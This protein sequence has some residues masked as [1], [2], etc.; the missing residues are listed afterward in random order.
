MESDRKRMNARLIRQLNMARIF[1]ALRV[2]PNSTQRELA[3]HAGL[4]QATVSTVVGALE[5]D[6]L[7]ERTI[8]TG[9]RRVGR[10]EANLHIPEGAGCL[11][12]ACLEPTTIRVIATD[13]TGRPRGHLQIAG[14]L[15][16]A[17]AL[18][19]LEEGVHDILS[20]CG[21]PSE[22]VKGLGVGVPALMDADGRLA[23]APNLGWRD[24][25]LLPSLQER[26]TMPVYA[27]N[28]TKAAGLAEKLFGSCQDV[29]DFVLIAGHSGLGA[30]LHLDGRLYRARSGFAGELGHVKVRPGG[31]R[32]GCGATGCLEAYLSESAILARLAD[33]GARFAALGEV[34]A[35]ARE[36]D[37]RVLE[38]LDETGAILGEACADLVNLLN[39][40]RI[41]VG[42][43]LTAVASYLLDGA[44]RIL[45]QRAL[46]PPLEQVH[47]GV[48][49]LGVEGV[50][51][52]G[53]ALAMEGFLG[54]PAWLAASQ[55]GAALP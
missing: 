15:D 38:L 52:G 1:H 45:R 44:S 53:V 10:P 3:R 43:N 12:G 11:I 33:R 37:A 22:A 42:G 17:V 41:V 5:R 25:A 6:G 7:I 32:C 24:V 23:Y 19:R 26:F 29:H 28:D 14:S 4:D 51:M 49:P 55:I 34:A 20:G 2:R 27:D 8:P 48:S 47:L 54:L 46:R 18:D 13:L 21:T 9:A 31:R 50:T 39:P 40:E 35:A 36:G 16:V 30:A